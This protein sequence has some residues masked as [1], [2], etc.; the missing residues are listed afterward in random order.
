[1][2]PPDYLL[3]LHSSPYHLKV[4]IIY[5]FCLALVVIFYGIAIS[6]YLKPHS[7]V[8]Q[9]ENKFI[10][11]FYGIITPMLHTFIYSLQQ[12]CE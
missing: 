7:Q 5:H 8:F 6:M 3:A 4:L 10:V 11:I 1:M 12:G 9:H 2:D